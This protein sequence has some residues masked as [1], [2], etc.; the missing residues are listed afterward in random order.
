MRYSTYGTGVNQSMP[1]AEV[2]KNSVLAG[3][4]SRT[5]PKEHETQQG[6]VRGKSEKWNQ[7]GH[8]KASERISSIE[9]S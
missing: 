3:H 7:S 1:G 6:G 5:S 8:Q 9:M 2:I 4:T